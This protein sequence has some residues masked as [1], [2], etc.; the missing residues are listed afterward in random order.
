MLC[1]GT[2]DQI[3]PNTQTWT[4]GRVSLKLFRCNILQVVLVAIS[5]TLQYVKLLSAE[6]YTAAA[7]RD[8]QA[9]GELACLHTLYLFQLKQVSFTSV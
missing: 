5:A 2:D 4:T 6:D 1:L 8:I 9:A 7:C 3:L